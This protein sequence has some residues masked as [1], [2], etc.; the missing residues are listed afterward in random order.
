MIEVPKKQRG[1]DI[2]N[3]NTLTVAKR[4]IMFINWVPYALGK[5]YEADLASKDWRYAEKG[6]ATHRL[7]ATDAS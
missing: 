3:L 6:S 2:R 1:P 5:P 7:T 4:G